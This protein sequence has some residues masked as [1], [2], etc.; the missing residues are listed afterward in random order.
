MAGNVKTEHGVFAGEALFF[1]PGRSLKQFERH[2]RGGS[3]GSK[4]SVLAR[5]ARPR[6][7]LQGSNGVIHRRQHGFSRTERIHGARLNEAFKHT[8]VQKARFDTFA[9][10]IERCEFSLTQTRFT[11]RL[12]GVL[13]NILDRS[14]T[15]ANRFADG[16]EIDI[17]LI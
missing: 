9:E 13:A 10:I 1:A 15:E 7:A 12:G 5:L 14:E 2:R 3:G 8:L 17:A 4:Q 11:S 6:S 16:R